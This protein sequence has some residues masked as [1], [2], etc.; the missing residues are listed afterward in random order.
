MLTHLTVRNFKRFESVDIELG[1]PVVFFGPNNSGKTSA[2]QALALWDIGL[3][4]WNEKWAGHKT[5]AKRPGVAVNRRLFA[6]AAT[7]GSGSGGLTSWLAGFTVAASA[8]RGLDFLPC[9][10]ERPTPGPG[11]SVRVLYAF[12]ADGEFRQEDADGVLRA[13][14]LLQWWFADRLGGPTFALH[15]PEPQ[16][17]QLAEP[18]AFYIEDAWVRVLHGVQRCA[19]VGYSGDDFIWVVYADVW[20]YDPLE[21]VRET[22]RTCEG[23]RL[24]AGA[25]GITM[26]GGW[27][28]YG[29]V[30]SRFRQCG[31]YTGIDRWIGGT[32][33]ELGHALG[34]SHPPGCGEGTV[35]TCDLHAVMASGFGEW[36]HAHLREEDKAILLA[37]PFIR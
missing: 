8:T 14:E 5:P 1:S 32:A 13:M 29:L 2:M 4:R 20:D 30:T 21:V 37:S 17:C 19:P 25:T 15:E 22:L 6:F 23:G 3:R 9:E 12:P 18:E 7:S 24:G 31:Y 27:D 35:E 36:P 16:P 11:P 33:H 34:L 26:M 28:L 10:R